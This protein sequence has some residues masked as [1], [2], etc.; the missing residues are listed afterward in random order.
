MLFTGRSKK[1]DIVRTV[2]MTKQGKANR[3]DD[4]GYYQN[5]NNDEDAD[6]KDEDAN[7]KDEDADDKHDDG[8]DKNEDADEKDEDAD[9]EHGEGDDKIAF[10]VESLLSGFSECKI[11]ECRRMAAD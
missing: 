10:K 4:E 11:S 9:D 6:D 2:M 8:D 7:I 1:L 3:N 5:R